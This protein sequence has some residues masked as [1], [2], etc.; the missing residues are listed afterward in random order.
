MQ[1][2]GHAQ[3]VDIGEGTQHFVGNVHALHRFADIFKAGFA[4]FNLRVHFDLQVLALHQLAIAK[5]L[6][7]GNDKALLRSDAVSGYAGFFAG[8]LDQQLAHLRCGMAH[9]QGGNLNRVAR[10]CG[11]QIW[12][13]GGVPQH[14][15]D[16]SEVH[17]QLVC[18]QLAQGRAH[19][20]AQ[21]HV[22]VVGGH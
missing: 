17:I 21:V 11:A 1:H 20:C 22:A 9:G 2:A 19:A 10:N 14:H 12:C 8:Q 7:T 16:G 13:A 4:Q 5:A 3:V 15:G 6:T 18:H